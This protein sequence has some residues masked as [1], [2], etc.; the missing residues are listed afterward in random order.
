[1]YVRSLPQSHDRKEGGEKERWLTSEWRQQQ[2]WN[3]MKIT[4]PNAS[5]PSCLCCFLCYHASSPL[6]RLL[7]RQI[8]THNRRLTSVSQNG[9]SKK[10][11]TSSTEL[12]SNHS[13]FRTNS[14]VTSWSCWAFDSYSADTEIL[15]LH[16]RPWF[17]TGLTRV[18]SLILSWY[19]SIEFTFI[20]CGGLYNT[21][22]THTHTGTS[23]KRY[24]PFM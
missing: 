8:S 3:T 5:F 1:M 11:W 18:S 20:L 14:Y 19:S 21:A 22:I 15:C 23:S 9:L 10:I 2:N 12:F 7:L 16:W 17:I 6:L 13:H 24:R 4:S